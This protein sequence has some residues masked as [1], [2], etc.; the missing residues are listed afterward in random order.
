MA[1]YAMQLLSSCGRCRSAPSTPSGGS[2]E[3]TYAK[4]TF[5]FRGLQYSF[6]GNCFHLTLSAPTGRFIIWRGLDEGNV[7]EATIQASSTFPQSN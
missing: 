4:G 3:G 7:G 5:K 2:I 6:T 1:V